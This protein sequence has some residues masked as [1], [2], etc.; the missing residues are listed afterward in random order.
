MGEWQSRNDS[1]GRAAT[2]SSTAFF[3][4]FYFALLWIAKPEGGR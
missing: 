3:D 1:Q 2:G 4:F